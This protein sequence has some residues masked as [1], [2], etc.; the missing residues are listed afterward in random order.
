M[1][2]TLTHFAAWLFI[3]A[4][5]WLPTA[6]RG[7]YYAHTPEGKVYFPAPTKLFVQVENAADLEV[8]SA[9]KVGITRISERM[10]TLPAETPEL[11]AAMLDELKTNKS[12]AHAAPVLVYEGVEHVFTRRLFV[13]LKRAQDKAKLAQWAEQYGCILGEADA[14]SPLT[15]ALTLLPTTQRTALDLANMLS[16]SRQYA[17]AEPEWMLF[18]QLLG[19]P[20][21]DPDLA[22]QW[23]I[24]NN[25][26]ASPDQYFG[27][28]ASCGVADADVDAYEAWTLGNVTGSGIRI[29]IIDD[30][31]DI[32]NQPDL[33]ANLVAGYDATGAGW[34]DYGGHGTAVAGIAAAKG[35]NGIGIAGIAYDA[36]IVPVKIFWGGYT[37]T[38]MEAN[39]INWAWSTGQADVLNC[40]WGGGVPSVLLQQA[41]DNATTKGRNGKGSLVIVA[42][43][44]SDDEVKFPARYEP[45]IAVGGTTMYDKRKIIDPIGCDNVYLV[46]SYGKH[47]DVAAPCISVRTTYIGGG[48]GPFGGTSAAAPVVSG[49]AALLLSANPSLTAAKARAIL[50]RSCDKVGGYSYTNTNSNDH[51]NGTWHQEMGYGRVNAYNA[52]Q[53]ASAATYDLA[54]DISKPYFSA[55]C[56]G[57]FQPVLKIANNG[58]TTITSFTISY[59]VDGGSTQTQNWVGNLVQYSTATVKLP[60]LSA[61]NG[62]HTLAVSVVSTSLNGSQTDGYTA[63]NTRSITFNIA[64]TA[65]LP[66]IEDFESY[67]Y[68]TNAW[69]ISNPDNNITWDLS[70]VVGTSGSYGYSASVNCYDYDTNTARDALISRPFDLSGYTRATLSFDYAYRFQNLGIDPAYSDYKDSLFVYVSTD[71]GA[72]FPD[73]IYANGED[74]SGTFATVPL[75][76]VT[77]YFEP[78][79]A[80]QWGRTPAAGMAYVNLDLSAYAGQTNVRLK[81]ELRSH[82]GNV[83]YL[84]NIAVRATPTATI[85]GGGAKCSGASAFPDISIGFTGAAPWTVTYTD[86]VTPV[87]LTNVDV[88]PYVFT[89]AAT[90][91]YS[92]VSVSNAAGA[93]SVSGSVSVSNLS[94]ETAPTGV[95]LTPA[96]TSVCTSGGTVT[97]TATAPSNSLAG[98]GISFNGTNQFITMPTLS[99]GT[100]EFTIEAW[101]KPTNFSGIR[102]L[103]FQRSTAST[104]NTDALWSLEFTSNGDQFIARVRTTSNALL[105]TPYTAASYFLNTWH[106]IAYVYKGIPASNRYQVYVYVDGEINV[107]FG[108][109]ATSYT[110]ANAG[111]LHYV[112][113]G[114]NGSGTLQRYFQGEMDEIRYWNVARTQAQ[115]KAAYTKTIPATT[116][117]LLAY[118]RADEASGTSLTNATGGTAAT[119]SSAAMRNTSGAGISW[120]Y[121]WSPRTNLSFG[122]NSLVAT[123]SPT[124][125][126]AYR[127]TASNPQTG[128]ATTVSSYIS[129]GGDLSPS[130]SPSSATLCTGG[131]VTLSAAVAAGSIA[132]TNL[133]LDGTNDY[134]LLPNVPASGSAFTIEAWVRPSN[135]TTNADYEILRQNTSG[136]PTWRLAFTGNGTALTFGINTTSGYQEFSTAISSASYVN[137]WRHLAAVYDGSNQ[138]LYVDGVLVGSLAWTGTLTGTATQHNIG[139]NGGTT[140]FFAGQ[141]DELRL[142]TT[143]RTATQIAN[144]RLLT[145]SASSTGLFAYYPFNEEVGSTLQDVSSNMYNGSVQN[146]ATWRAANAAPLVPSYAWSPATGLSS[147]TT[148]STIASPTSTTTYTVTV[149]DALNGC[150]STATRTVTVFSSQPARS[151]VL[152]GGAGSQNGTSWANAYAELRD[153]LSGCPAAEIWVAQGTYT[154]S[155]TTDRSASF[156]IPSSTKVYGGFVGGEGSLAARPSSRL[157]S[158]ILSGNIGKA[159]SN[160]NSYHVVR[161][162]NASAA[163]VLDGCTIIGG[164]ANG[165]APDHLGAGIYNSATAGG[166]SSPIISNCQV[167]GNSASYGGGMANVATAATASPSLQNVL[168]AGNKASAA[169]GGI[170]NATSGSGTASPTLLHCTLAHNSGS[171]IQH[172]GSSGGTVNPSFRNSIAWGNSANGAVNASATGT[173]EYSILEGGYPTGGSCNT[174]STSSPIFISPVAT[175][176]APTTAGNYRIACNSP[177]ADAGNNTFSGSLTQDLDNQVRTVNSTVDMGAFEQRFSPAAASLPGLGAVP[178]ADAECTDGSGWTHYYVSATNTLLLSIQKN[179]QNPGSL[180]DGIFAVMAG[181]P[182]ASAGAVQIQVAPYIINPSG[183][184][185]MNRYW[186]ITPTTQLSGNVNVR[187]Y[188]TTTDFTEVNTALGGILASETSLYFYKIENDDPSPA[189]GHAGIPAGSYKQYSYGLSPSLT[190]WASGS[191]GSNKYAEYVVSSFSGG[192]G[193]GGGTSGQGAL[194]VS[195]LAVNANARWVAGTAKAQLQWAVEN[196]QQVQTYII[197]QAQEQTAWRE[198]GAVEAQGAVS[199]EF[200]SSETLLPNQRYFYRIRAVDFNGS[201]TIS[202]AVEVSAEAA[203]GMVI[204]PNPAETVLHISLP[205]A[206]ETPCDLVNTLGQVVRSS[207]FTSSGTIDVSSLPAGVYIVQCRLPN[208][209]LSQ[210]VQIH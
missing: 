133:A 62:T 112:G 173:Y 20:P 57:A 23:V 155:G 50:E 172:D 2:T 187:S 204:F 44:N 131:S 48:I 206:E 178:S 192:G 208:S 17:F 49:V 70:A 114:A 168:V 43:G 93:G 162:A 138:L 22:S 46:T 153:A 157:G 166:T 205:T 101:V 135:I 45:C 15:F 142:W 92:L 161:F 80:S 126:Q 154:P 141:I 88:N 60:S 25:A 94:T 74:G 163:T 113:V 118:Y 31:M 63:D 28:A 55:D 53:L 71:C 56:S 123:A 193:G 152:S 195:F 36:T 174:I 40:S 179:G 65:S 98:R 124:G 30:G 183:W 5:L 146:G 191:Y 78:T 9:K 14:Y 122:N 117:G 149:S 24:Q 147:T 104:N 209:I 68:E 207:V 109:T 170:W 7:Q 4:A 99:P 37:T 42:A 73:I 150:S 106:H 21:N 58:S 139:S 125:S 8:L 72:S 61:S 59:Q 185:V 171:G 82:Y 165:S 39:A 18:N 137:T 184:H 16:E 199:Y 186:D 145:V 164:N 201:Q 76:G 51:P 77:D 26:A 110:L 54:I 182:N 85:S 102:T 67:S 41:I 52:I 11:F 89:P 6:V 202:D 96:R 103:F 66:F 38:A 148:A 197:E 105:G 190:N 32:V 86:G 188:Y 210:K 120:D 13:G 181:Q 27:I 180:N 156:L 127:F 200:L 136:S 3:G 97:L 107:T 143:A 175:A 47:L 189:K 140:S 95:T 64:T 84:D 87:T 128:C 111:T 35:N 19:S 81:F 132:E 203:S 100:T 177:A 83:F 12:V 108:G 75:D 151:F 194:P 160:D 29:A 115:I 176:N 129:D 69:S 198:I 1:K 130:I 34:N 90:G 79:S 169:G 91:T 144:N 33:T 119:L 167:L 10:M 134:G 158:T 121:A 196:E 116:T 159:H